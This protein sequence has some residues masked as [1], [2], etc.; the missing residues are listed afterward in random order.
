MFLLLA[1]R[2]KSLDSNGTPPSSPQS[3]RVQ[4]TVRISSVLTHNSY[5]MVGVGRLRC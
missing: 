4:I 1:Y 2:A 3:L 5:A